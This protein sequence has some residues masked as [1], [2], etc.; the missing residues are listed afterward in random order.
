MLAGCWQ[1]DGD[2]TGSSVGSRRVFAIM[3]TS[4]LRPAARRTGV[5]IA[6]QHASPL[7][8]SLPHVQFRCG[9]AILRPGNADAAEIWDKQ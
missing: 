2:G 9:H 8:P 5:P 3:A 4:V 6:T 1:A 7:P